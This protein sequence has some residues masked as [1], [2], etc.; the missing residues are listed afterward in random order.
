MDVLKWKK[1]SLIL[2]DS[3]NKKNKNLP[4]LFNKTNWIKKK[5]HFDDSLLSVFD[6][7]RF[8]HLDALCMD[9]FIFLHSFLTEIL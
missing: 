5:I 8:V 6:A 3:S 7:G 4:P 1:S 9:V 2:V